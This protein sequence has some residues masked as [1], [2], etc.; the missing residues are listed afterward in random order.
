MFV[1]N[2]F[3]K[4]GNSGEEATAFHRIMKNTASANAIVRLES[5]TDAQNTKYNVLIWAITFAGLVIS[6]AIVFSM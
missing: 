2:L 5:K 1:F 3:R 4:M 6:A